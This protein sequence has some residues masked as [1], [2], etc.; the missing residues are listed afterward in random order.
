MV[1]ETKFL[2]FEEGKVLV[3]T[4]LKTG[5]GIEILNKLINEKRYLRYVFYYLKLLHTVKYLSNHK[6]KRNLCRLENII[7]SKV[8]QIFHLLCYNVKNKKLVC[9]IRKNDK[10][11]YKSFKK[12]KGLFKLEK[13]FKTYMKNIFINCFSKCLFSNTL[14]SLK[15]K[16]K[17]LIKE[18]N[19]SNFLSFERDYKKEV[20]NSS[21]RF[22]FLN[23]CY[24]YHKY[25]YYNVYQYG[26][27]NYIGMC[28][29]CYLLL[30]DNHN[31]SY[32][33]VHQNEYSFSKQDTI[34]QPLIPYYYKNLPSIKMY[35]HK[36]NIK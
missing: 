15:M 10:C 31:K 3:T 2:S 21:N 23:D 36:D 1:E 16:N 18:N 27:H 6:I 26:L 34:I 32:E 30:H 20:D 12:I 17:N 35:H 5:R 28:P 19:K 4:S 25:R 29:K 14:S 8:C 24:K 11:Y 13:I 9:N 7:K 22:I 33:N